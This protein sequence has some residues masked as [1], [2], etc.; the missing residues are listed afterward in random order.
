MV[1]GNFC[2]SLQSASFCLKLSVTICLPRAVK[3][4]MKYVIVLFT[5]IYSAILAGKGVNRSN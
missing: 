5:V 1:E 3:S 4:Q 2:K